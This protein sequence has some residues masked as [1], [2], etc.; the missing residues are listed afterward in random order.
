MSDV[1][2]EIFVRNLK[3]TQSP[4]EEDYVVGE[5]ETGTKLFPVKSLKNLFYSA[6]CYE[7]LEKL[8]ESTF[9]EGDVCYTS[10]YHMHN[11]GGGAMY[12]IVYE[13]TTIK[14]GGL[15]HELITS[16]TLRA[17]MVLMDNR[18]NVHQFGA[19]G[20]GMKD[21]T[22]AIQNAINTGMQI[23]FTCGKSYKITSP[24]KLNNSNQIINFNNA[25]IVPYNCYAISIEGTE[26]ASVQNVELNNLIIKC[27]NDGNGIKTS[28]YTKNICLNN[29]RF[30]G[31]HTNNKGLLIDS[32]ESFKA[33][34]GII[35]GQEYNGCA[36]HLLSDNSENKKRRI[37]FNDITVENMDAFCKIG[38]NDESTAIIFED[39]EFNNDD[40]TES[41]LSSTFYIIGNLK[42][43]TIRNFSSIN[44]D[45]FL[46][47]SSEVGATITVDNLF[48]YDNRSIFKLNSIAGGNKVVLKGNH[49]Y[50]GTN[51]DPKYVI[52]DS[53]FSNLY[54]YAC[55][56]YEEDITYNATNTDAS[57][58]VGTLYDSHLPEMEDEVEINSKTSKDLTV[59][60]LCN[61]RFNWTGD[62][63]LKNIIGFE[64]Q[65][66]TV[67]STTSQ[68][69]SS[70]GNIVLYPEEPSKTFKEAMSATPY[71]FKCQSGRWVKMEK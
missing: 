20:D 15:V 30:N 63:V 53:M 67:R 23:D 62:L 7:T 57:K 46:Y 17:K 60:K 39:C 13:P 24:L 70:G 47:T 58:I 42:E 32:C 68:E 45:Y 48:V 27:N 8:K 35:N 34:H 44:T 50:K 2:D 36:I 26:T 43:V 40:L 18:I 31:I 37:V 59:N 54:N 52:V 71:T 11:D 29:F 14:D 10:G 25:T 4:K 22:K 41:N 65:I 55:I 21:D 5:T 66:V 33:C 61:A 16:N 9:E 19:Y 12:M 64:G 69:I 49:T 6:Q 1:Y 51:I 28:E 56:T 38:Y 3:V